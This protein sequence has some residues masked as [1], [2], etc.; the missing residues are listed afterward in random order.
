M[1]EGKD[2]GGKGWREEMEKE[3]DGGGKGSASLS[4]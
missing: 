2:E 3:R 4:M 1:K